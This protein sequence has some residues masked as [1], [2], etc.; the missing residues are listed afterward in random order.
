MDSTVLRRRVTNEEDGGNT[1]YSDKDDKKSLDKIER[2]QLETVRNWHLFFALLQLASAIAI[3]ITFAVVKKDFFKATFLR[4]VFDFDAKEVTI[5]TVASG[6]N[7]FGILLP[8]PFLTSTFHFIQW[9]LINCHLNG[10]NNDLADRY[11]A[12][13]KKG[14]NF[15]RW[16]EYS[17]SA[18]LMTVILFLLCGGTNFYL[19]V[20]VGIICNIALQWQGFMFEVFLS[21]RHLFDAGI[22]MMTGFIIFAGQWATLISYFVTTINASSAGGVPPIV[23]ITFIGV[24]FGYLV[25]PV[26]QLIYAARRGDD[27][28]GWSTYAISMDTGSNVVKVYLDVTVTVALIIGAFSS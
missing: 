8:V 7:V 25:F 23:Y 24:G 28:N 16:L 18:S 19:L 27:A 21:L 11:V 22:A 14:I 17:L 15:V 10:D 9:F 1:G 12:N 4:D 20:L 26:I 2:E 6:V 13:L 3:T 5:V